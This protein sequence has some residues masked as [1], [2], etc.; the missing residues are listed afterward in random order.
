MANKHI[1]VATVS[2]THVISNDTSILEQVLAKLK[3]HD[4][5]RL[6]AD[7]SEGKSVVE[8]LPAYRRPRTLE[9][10]GAERSL[11]VATVYKELNDATRATETFYRNKGWNMRDFTDH[12]AAIEWLIS[13]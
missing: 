9:D 11:K 6:L 13:G 2:G 12:D 5:L 4:C 7:Y 8:T 10:L 1:L 3:E